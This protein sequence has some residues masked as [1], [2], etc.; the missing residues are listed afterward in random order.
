MHVAASSDHPRLPPFAL[1][2]PDMGLDHPQ[3]HQVLTRPAL[4]RTMDHTVRTK[5][6]KSEVCCAP[7]G[8][9]RA[10]MDLPTSRPESFLY[11][12]HLDLP[13]TPL[14]RAMVPRTCL[15]RIHA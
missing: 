5:L 3:V 8:A 11:G 15:N 14:N 13:R 7:R 12:P 4:V 9:V 10:T 1:Y 2:A 6:P